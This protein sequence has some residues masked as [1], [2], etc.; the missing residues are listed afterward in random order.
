LLRDNARR[1]IAVTSATT[2][3]ETPA[4]RGQGLEL[5]VIVF[6]MMM[7]AI[8]P[9]VIARRTVGVAVL[10]DGDWRRRWR[11]VSDWRRSIDHSWGSVDDGR[12][13]RVH[14]GRL[15]NDHWSGTKAAEELVEDREGTEPQRR[16]G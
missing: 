2:I 8:R 16:I 4:L 9:V 12:W 10:I 13:R 7:L 14:H 11:I 1:A 6:V 3:E 15:R 5:L